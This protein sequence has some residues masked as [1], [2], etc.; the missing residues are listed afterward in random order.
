MNCSGIKKEWGNIGKQS[1]LLD[2]TKIEKNGQTSFCKKFFNFTKPSIGIPDQYEEK[3]DDINI[4]LASDVD[5]PKIHSTI[6][7]II[8]RNLK[9]MELLEKEI[10]EIIES[11]HK[12]DENSLQ[13]SKIKTRLEEID[14]EMNEINIFDKWEKYEML[15]I[16]ILNEYAPIMSN[17]VKGIIDSS[18]YIETIDI[19]SKRIDLIIK[20]IDIIKSL[21]IIDINISSNYDNYNN[22][23]ACGLDLSDVQINS[24]GK[25]EC[26]CGF[27]EDDNLHV[28]QEQGH[29]DVIKMPVIKSKPDIL[30]T[31]EKW[32]SRFLGE[33]MEVY[34]KEQMFK[35][36]DEFCIKQGWSTGDEVKLNNDN[37]ATFSRLIDIMFYTGYSEYYK[38]KNIIRNEYW[39]WP[40]PIMSEEQKSRFSNKIVISQEYYHKH[41]LRKQ[42]LKQDI[43]GWYH[44]KDAGCDFPIS[45]FKLPKEIKILEESDLVYKKVCIDSDMTFHAIL[46]INR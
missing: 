37:D 4:Y 26:E 22:C 45:W 44:I 39:G 33:S 14:E 32:L 2:K 30:N 31:M 21:N 9:Q 20:Y 23:P 29:I 38:I 46:E 7:S 18:N 6:K 24:V 41:A 5:L 13:F 34:P 19:I 3:I 25:Y 8:A 11:A 12:I 43:R 17:K 27:F 15:S 16:P 28:I 10:E 1:K 36:F 42:N 40:L 35:K